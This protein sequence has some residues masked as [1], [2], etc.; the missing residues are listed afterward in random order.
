MKQRQPIFPAL[1]R[2][3]GIVLSAAIPLVSAPAHVYA[4]QGSCST[5]CY[6]E[7]HQCKRRANESGLSGAQQRKIIEDCLRAETECINKK[8][9]GY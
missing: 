8:C 9:H 1:M 5:S 3:A 7:S 2:A 4:Q 6:A